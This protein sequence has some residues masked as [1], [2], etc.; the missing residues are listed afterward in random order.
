MSKSKGHQSE[1]VA[2]FAKVVEQMTT[3][4][5]KDLYD[6][7]LEEKDSELKEKGLKQFRAADDVTR[8]QMLKI[9]P[10][11]KS[12]KPRAKKEKKP[13]DKNAPPGARNAWVLFSK[14]RIAELKVPLLD[15]GKNAG[16]AQKLA[17]AQAH[18]EWLAMSAD[19]KKP[20]E[21][22]AAKDKERAKRDREEYEAKKAEVIDVDADNNNEDESQKKKSKA[23]DNEDDDSSST[24]SSSVAQVPTPTPAIK[25]DPKPSVSP[26]K[27]VAKKA[28]APATVPTKPT[29]AAT[30]ATTTA[31][32]AAKTPASGAA[33]G[34]K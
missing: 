27:S 18:A 2:D 17:R 30:T 13:K 11:A 12:G 7:L 24:T 23:I 15:E 25:S 34:K 1:E 10:G 33:S 14:G 6:L 16:E 22:E 20:F 4:G 26:A 19:E 32:P 9:I 29:T 21:E 5:A 31:K 28:G 8:A 3:N